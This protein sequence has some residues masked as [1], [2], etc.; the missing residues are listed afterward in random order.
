M[1]EREYI[2]TTE[3]RVTATADDASNIALFMKRQ[4]ER[5]GDELTVKVESEA[6]PGEKRESIL[7]HSTN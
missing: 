1:T 2:I 7:F 4:A 5:C 6:W 3:I